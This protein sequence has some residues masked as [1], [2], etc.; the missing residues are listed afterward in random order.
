MT[1][2]VVSTTRAG[3]P[4]GRRSLLLWSALAVFCLWPVATNPGALNH[5]ELD[6]AHALAAGQPAWQWSWFAAA[7]ELFYRP[8]GHA[9]FA[10]QLQLSGGPPWSHLLSLLH[11]AVNC[12]LAAWVFVRLGAPARAAAPMAFL[13]TAVP[14]I[15][16]SAAAY[17]RTALTLLLLATAALTAR[18]R[19]TLLA[20]PCTVLAL[21]A[22]ETA[23]VFPLAA[24]L[25]NG[26]RP[27]WPRRTAALVTVLCAGFAAFRLLCGAGVPAYAMRL[28]EGAPLRLLHYVAFPYALGAAEPHQVEG[29]GW[30]SGL[31]GIAVLGWLAAVRRGRPA[32]AAMAL[33]MAPL[34]PVALLPGIHGNY[35]YLATPAL[36]WLLWA[37]CG[38]GS[39][40]DAAP[41]RRARAASDPPVALQI[42]TGLV[43]A[44]P[45]AV[46]ARS[47][48]TSH[49]LLG[50]AMSALEN[51]HR[52]LP[53]GDHPVEVVAAG[54]VAASAVRF[55]QHLEHVDGRPPLRV[56]AAST[57]SDALILA[58][59]GSIRGGP[60]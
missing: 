4:S 33:A 43:L 57:A 3:R 24:W 60:R 55:A 47:I 15:A 7:D 12:A 19:R 8:L 31:L 21:T 48:A 11:H 26:R 13:P 44:A 16:W 6:L 17:D 38:S 39:T 25:L 10:I 2:T 14:G 30:V 37:A 22:K 54:P 29:L 52:A 41:P 40:P 36:A 18:D 51:A 42:L 50:T 46:H 1:T 23:V 59:D 49:H 20:L 45:L 53:P 58:A 5:D 34:L 35:L 56:V 9:V 27:G 32:A 28:D